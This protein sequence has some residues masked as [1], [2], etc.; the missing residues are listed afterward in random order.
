[1][2]IWH[3]LSP[4]RVSPEDFI[5]VIEIPKGCNIKYE[6]DKESGHLIMDRI[7]YTSAHFP[8]NY[9]FIPLTLAQDDDPLDVVVFTS[10]P[11]QSMALVHAY[12]I[13]MIA[14]EDGGKRD[15]K[16]IALAKGDP[17]YNAY[18][19]I[20]ELPPH[21]M[22]AIVHFFTI[23]KELEKKKVA[24]EGVQNAAAARATIEDALRRYRQHFSAR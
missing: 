1:M 11:I 8:A 10:E 9:G 15:E 23:Y 22:D 3:D 17:V 7:L 21:V 20:D 19:D 14:M 5:A 18:T 4:T 12:P 24:V 2:N 13:G 6:L 16:I